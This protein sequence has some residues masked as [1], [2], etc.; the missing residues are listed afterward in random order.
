MDMCENARMR[1]VQFTLPAPYLL[2]AIVTT[3]VAMQHEGAMA[4][5][6]QCDRAATQS[7]TSDD[8]SPQLPPV[9]HSAD[10]HDSSTRTG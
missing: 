8:P 10:H 5:K 2:A 7:I 4:R 6:L 1:N 3:I 9:Q